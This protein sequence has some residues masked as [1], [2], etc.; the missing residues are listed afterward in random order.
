MFSTIIKDKDKVV[1]AFNQGIFEL[2]R[3]SGEVLQTKAQ[4]L[5]SELVPDSFC[6]SSVWLTTFKIIMASLKRPFVVRTVQLAKKGLSITLPTL[7]DGYQARNIFN[8]DE[9]GLFL[10][11]F[12]PRYQKQSLSWG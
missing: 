5:A 12:L 9:T 8:V 2:Q 1:S 6:C 4:E 3:I 7:K 10:S 11:C